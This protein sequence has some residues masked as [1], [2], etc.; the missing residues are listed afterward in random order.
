MKLKSCALQYFQAEINHTKEAELLRARR[1][2][3][4]APLIITYQRVLFNSKIASDENLQEYVQQFLDMMT[5]LCQDT[6]KSCYNSGRSSRSAKSY[7][8]E[9]VLRIGSC[10]SS[11]VFSERSFFVTMRV[12]GLR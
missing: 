11:H 7:K 5:Y 4:S 3:F 8:M 10:L 9:M 1:S 2:A 12:G 6:S